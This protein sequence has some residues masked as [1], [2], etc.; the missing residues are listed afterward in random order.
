MLPRVQQVMR[1]TRQ[2]INHGN[3]G[4]PGKI[5]SLFE[6]HTE[7]IRKGKGGKPTEFGKMVKIQEAEQQIVTHYEVYEQRPADAALLVAA[8]ELHRQQFARA[9][10]LVTADAGFFSAANE[11][12]AHDLGVKRISMPNHG[13]RSPQRRLLERKRWFRQAQRWRTGC[14][15]RISLLKRRHGLNRCRY[16][17][18]DGMKR[19]VGLGVIADN[20]INI[21][22][23]LS[24]AAALD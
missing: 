6:P 23:V 3:T 17:G 10:R 12:A 4:S 22:L 13:S 7:I 16:R 5:A 8:V 2:R 24:V 20:L 18:E 21:G 11:A 9:P 15:G 19:W 14:E 1:Q